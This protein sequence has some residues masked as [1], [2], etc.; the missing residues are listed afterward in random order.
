M[1]KRTPNKRKDGAPFVCAK[2]VSAT[3]EDMAQ[4]KL[5]KEIVPPTPNCGFGVQVVACA[6]I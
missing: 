3:G 2:D 5:W 4:L 6:T 1:P